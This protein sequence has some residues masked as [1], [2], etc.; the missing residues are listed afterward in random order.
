M[1]IILL[2]VFLLPLIPAS[3]Q[4]GYEQIKV[5]FF[6]L[7]I[8]LIGFIW[9]FKK[10]QV[11]WTNM[12]KAASFFILVLVATSF[13]G[14]DPWVS[15]LGMQPYFQGAVIYSDLF[16][17]FL[18]VKSSN[19]KLETYAKALVISA[20]VVS[21]LA[22]KDWVNLSILNIQIPTYAGR[23]VSTFGQP[24]FYAGFILLTLPFWHFLIKRKI[25]WWLL[26]GFLILALGIIISQSRTAQM[27]M[28]G[29]FIWWL[30]GEWVKGK[31]L[32][33][34][35][36]LILIGL[37]ALLSVFFNSGFFWNEVVEPYLTTNPDLT[38]ASVEN[39]VYIWPIA[40]ELVL[41]KPLI[42]YGLENIDQAFNNYFTVNKHK[43][44]EENLN[45][46]PVLISLKDLTIDRSHNYIL[47][48]LLFSGILGLIAWLL[49]I[50][51]IF[52]K[53]G[54]KSSDRG[55]N[56]LVV[57]LI[58]YLIWVQFQNQ[59]VVHLVYFWTIAGLIDRE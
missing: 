49:L 38:R 46:Y 34:G 14:L 57:S 16:L 25:S 47:D 21:L 12:T 31:L 41:Q 44:F 11:R 8:S 2:T 37:I 53:L 55:K 23:V 52:R 42:G 26:V 58:L 15:F 6:I 4:F 5:L 30:I 50:A 7:S 27:L 40:W 29:L 24:N 17:F 10:P 51:L 9:I 33:I 39:R 1:A 20:I 59:S 36:I 54:Q 18:M 45:I 3:Y 13:L 32:V 43:L 48:L 56:V 28:V 22:I 35:E 19:I